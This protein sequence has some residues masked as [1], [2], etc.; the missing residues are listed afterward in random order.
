MLSVDLSGVFVQ[1]GIPIN[2]MFDP[3]HT[4]CQVNTFCNLTRKGIPFDVKYQY[5][6]SIIDEVRCLV[7]DA[8]LASEATHLFMID[9][10]VTWKEEDFCRLLALGTK[11]ECVCGIYPMKRDPETWMLNA[12]G[13]RDVNEYGCLHIDGVGL[14]FCCVQR[15]VIQKLAAKADLME[16][17]E[18]DHPV[19]R[20]FHSD[21][22]KGRF[23]GE[24]MRFFADVADLGYKV[25]LDPSISLGHVGTKEYRGNFLEW[26]KGHKVQS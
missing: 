26:M 5:G 6:C 21:V 23:R 16:V 3:R 25:W 19:A 4:I 17:F 24:D 1:V 10:D 7:A 14:G 18:V 8:F 13:I 9:S 11:M 22:F 12:E 2:G 20:I 15:K